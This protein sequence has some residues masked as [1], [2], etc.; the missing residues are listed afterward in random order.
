MHFIS[1]ED[2]GYNASNM[3]KIHLPPQRIEKNTIR[4]LR[5]LFLQD[6]S[7]K[8]V[9][10]SMEISTNPV[11][12]NGKEFNTKRNAIDEF[13]LPAFG[14]QLKKGRNF[15]EAY[16]TDS[17]NAVIVN[18]AFAKSVGLENPIG[19]QLT[20]LGNKHTMTI[21]GVV[22]DYHYG[23]LKEKIEPQILNLG[24]CEY[25]IIKIEKGKIAQ[26]L[27][28]VEKVFRKT[29]PEHYFYYRF[30]DDE[31][32]SAYQS[33]KKWQ[34]IITYSAGLAILICCVGL[35]GLTSFAAQQRIKEIGIRKVLGASIASVTVLLSKDFLKLVIVAVIVASPIAWYVMSK[36]LQGFAYRIN[37]SLWMFMLAGLGAIF[38]ALVTVSFQAIKAAIANPVKSLRSE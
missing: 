25:V 4:V 18:E 27:P 38:I 10:S 7:V 2:L 33:D 19:Q 5:D 28:F 23:S 16:G 6:P 12:I 3:I 29:F 26:A 36:W 11:S 13:Y 1:K 30:L 22:K 37:I 14:I 31:N 8:Q 17:S 9:T 35:F 20:D 15:S 24:N 32:A 21:I 34:Q